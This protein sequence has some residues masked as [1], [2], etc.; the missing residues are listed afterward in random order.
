M[1]PLYERLFALETFGIKLGL[2]N[3]ACLCEALGHPE[4]AFRSIHIAGTNGKGSTTA[5][6][7]AGL[8]AA[9]ISAAR[10]TSPHL[11]HLRERFVIGQEPVDDVLLEAT[12]A[13]VLDVAERLVADGVLPAPPTFFEATTAIA[14][15]LFRRAQVE[16]A[17]IEVGLGG[18][19][20][21]TNVITPVV[22]AIT[23]IGLD[24]QEH[25]GTTRA[26]I[27]FE[28]AGIIKPGIPVVTGRIDSESADVIGAAAIERGA[29]LTS[30]IADTAVASRFDDGRAI[31]DVRSPVRD[32]GAIALGLRGAHQID[33][34]VVALR[35]ME[36]VDTAGIAMGAGAIVEGLTTAEWP[37]RLEIIELPGG[38][39]VL[40]D[41]AHN[42][43]GATALA[44]YLTRWHKDR[45]TLVFAAMHDK[46]V[47][48][49]LRAL[50][51][52]V[53]PV[54]VTAPAIRR[55]LPP[56]ALATIVAR[57]DPAR[58]V[59]IEEQVDRAVERALQLHPTACVA[60]S[61]FLVGGVRDALLAR[62]ILR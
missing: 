29:P 23:S 48:G 52:S 50:L 11:S 18:R 44:S 58:L 51:P 56:A 28:K 3:I 31:V 1:P 59:V 61:I 30:A 32:Y 2:T 45:P 25:L 16:T 43:D 36:I 22:S 62:A 53:G 26:S 5:M 37:G 54:V 14:F 15:E 46:D 34:A 6:V 42:P 24:H 21:S 40:L 10:Y 7:H 4:R 38:H 13:H 8:L 49:M 39:R 57:I 35:V 20:D 19:F 41:A 12:A 27:A 47:V 60:G 33:N 17:V 9:G 55:A